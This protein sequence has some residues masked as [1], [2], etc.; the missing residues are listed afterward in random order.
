MNLSRSWLSLLAVTLVTTDVRDSAGDEEVLPTKPNFIVFLTDNLGYGDIGPFGSTKHRTPNLDR[1][2]EE[3]MKLTHFYVTS[4]VCTPSRSSVMTGCYPRRVNLHLSD[5]GGRVLQPVSPIGLHPNEIT[6]ARLLKDA[7]YATACIGKWHLGD[8]PPFLPT[9]HGFD[10]YWGVPY[11]DDMTPREGQVWP[12]LPLMRNLEVMEAPT[13]RD[14]LTQKETKEAIQFIQ[15]NKDR[16]FF[17]YI[18]H[19][20]PGSTQAP[21]ASPAFK[22]KSN[23]GPWGDSIEEL[24]W[25]AGQVLTKLKRLGLDANTLVIWTSDNGAP[26]RTPPQGSNAP[27]GGWGYTTAEGG[28]RVPAVA[29]WPGKVPAGTVCSELATSMDLYAT[30]ANLAQSAMPSD[31]IID[32]QDISDLLMG[33]NDAKTRH[34]SFYYYDGPQL[35]AI[36]SGPWKLYVPLEE[37][38]KAGA[39]NR[40]AA[41]QA[42]QLYHV[43]DDPAEVSDLLDRHPEIDAS[44]MQHAERARND[45]GDVDRP[46]KGQRPVGRVAH[47]TARLLAPSRD[48]T[49]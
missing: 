7:G 41:K 33:V 28:Q 25:S 44:L 8:Q 3:G 20:M 47:P 4:G 17:L 16:P 23:N 11:S 39:G 49:R 24:D 13:N 40:V 18:P 30:F 6:I 1:M 19:A 45:L 32:G 12:E 43:V 29:W 26:R 42:A 37:K 36:R 48:Q 46:G 35:Q 22:G 10:H 27:L 15:D 34:E 21:F 31:R 38:W 5:S 2:A 9:A 14:D